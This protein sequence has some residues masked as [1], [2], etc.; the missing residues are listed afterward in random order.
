MKKKIII[1][2][3]ICFAVSLIVCLMVPCAINENRKN[4]PY[5][6]VEEKKYN[7]E[8][9]QKEVD[10]EWELESVSTVT[11][12]TYANPEGDIIIYYHCRTFYRTE[13]KVKR[14]GLNTLA[15]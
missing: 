15:L 12:Y 8:S 7:V 14:D 2:I 10:E 3:G 4:A 9:T 5:W 1:G 11:P 13:E 6:Q